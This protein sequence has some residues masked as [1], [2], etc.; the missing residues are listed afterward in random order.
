MPKINLGERFQKAFGFQPGGETET[1]K[2]TSFGNKTGIDQTKLYTASSKY[3]D[4]VTLKQ[5]DGTALT[6]GDMM[7]PGAG[8]QVFAPPLMISWSRSKKLVETEIDGGDGVVVERYNGGQWEIKMDGLLIEMKQRQ[9]PLAQLTTVT[10]LFN[11][12]DILAVES[13]IFDALK[14]KSI[15]LTSFNVAMLQGFEDT[16]SISFEGKSIK[17]VEFFLKNIDE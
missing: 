10:K 3:L 17:P 9:F 13:E 11:V 2:Q 4:V 1:A 12:N 6:F 7:N 8:L 15:Y 16:A 14:I 5:P